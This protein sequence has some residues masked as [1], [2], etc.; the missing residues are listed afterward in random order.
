MK[1][2]ES[3]GHQKGRVSQRETIKRETDE[4][5]K[6]GERKILRKKEIKV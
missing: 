6:H 4:R 5:G 1:S 3:G 2:L